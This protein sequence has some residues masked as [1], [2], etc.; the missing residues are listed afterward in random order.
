MFKKYWQDTSGNFSTMAVLASLTIIGGVG[1]SVDYLG[2][3]QA[4]ARLQSAADAAA[5]AAV[6]S[7]EDDLDAIRLI[8]EDA[9]QP[10]E[11]D[12]FDI[13][14]S[15][16]LTDG[17]IITHATAQYTPQIMG[18]FGFGRQTLRAKAESPLSG[19]GRLD[20]TLVLDV[21][22]SMDFDGKLDA[23]KLAVSDFIDDFD[24]SGGDIRVSVVPFS[25]YVNVGTQYSNQPWIDNS[26]DGTTF[27]PVTDIDTEGDVCTGGTVLE[28]C[29]RHQ[30]GVSYQGEC[31]RCPGGY[32][33]GVEVTTIVEPLREWD[34]CVGS[35][36][37]NKAT[38][39][40]YAG[41]PFPA[42]YDDGR[43]GSYRHTQYSCPDALLPLTDDLGVVRTMVNGLN[44]RGDT[45]MPSGLAWG[46]RTLDEDIPFGSPIA[47]QTRQKAII[48]MTDGHNTISRLGSD[49]YHY[50]RSG[51]N[52]TRD[53]NKI[54]ER[55]C[56]GLASTDILVYT[57][58]YALP[59]GADS[60]ETR[61]L[62]N[63]CAT[64]PDNFFNSGNVDL[65]ETF[66][67]IGRDLSQIRL[68]N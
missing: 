32:T 50:G 65:S 10:F 21:T 53:A 68:I 62:L 22:G 36:Q 18:I 6:I 58:A 45:Y 3:T 61:A 59:D 35:R 44:A 9:V 2:L 67:A 13:Q 63:D 30:D 4:S 7:G 24:A 8:S 38:E 23:M 56:D 46:W 15:P 52:A 11:L 27:P 64:V 57:I 39:P 37:G 55:I 14:I 43:D 66:K 51:D 19:V 34:G 49:K 29:T 48:L 26:E 12:G 54:T 60:D 41:S 25:Q 17:S 33:G 31:R 42:V 28:V 47:G 20:I 16:E 1:L 5:I 40:Q